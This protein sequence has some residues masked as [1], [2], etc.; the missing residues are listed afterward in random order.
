MR[1]L[2]SKASTIE[3]LFGLLSERVDKGIICD[4]FGGI[5]TIGAAF[6]ERG[7]SVWSGDILTNA[8]YF[9]VAKLV[10]QRTSSF[11]GIRDWYGL[12]T[13]EDVVYKLNSVKRENSWF[14]KE[15]SELRKYFTKENASK[16]AG[17]CSLIKKWD[18]NGLISYTEK[19]VLLASLVNSMDKVANT[20]GTYYAYL[21]GWYRKS[22]KSFS[23]EFIEPIT[24]ERCM[25]C[26]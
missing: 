16:I 14:V 17:C 23:Y 5:G 11:K 15:Y 25:P 13:V 8:H 2:G 20:A 3:Q 18:K 9:Q 7:Y 6:K 1:Y 21:K 10:R 12:D 19:A 24:R 4:P 26:I 22:S